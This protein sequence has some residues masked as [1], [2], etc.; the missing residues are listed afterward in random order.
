MQSEENPRIGELRNV[1]A[2]VTGAICSALQSL[3]G[4]SPLIAGKTPTEGFLVVFDLFVESRMDRLTVDEAE[5]LG[6]TRLTIV[7]SADR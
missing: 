5:L 2:I 1:L 7:E 6:R 4:S 3:E